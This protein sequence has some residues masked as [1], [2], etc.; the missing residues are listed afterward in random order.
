ML[1][2]RAMERIFRSVHYNPSKAREGTTSSGVDIYPFAS[3][4]G[5]GGRPCTRLYLMYST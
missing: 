5:C 3:R 4:D 1:A 2:L